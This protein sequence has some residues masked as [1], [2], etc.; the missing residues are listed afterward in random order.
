MDCPL[1]LRLAM[2]HVLVKVMSAQMT[3]AQVGRVLLCCT[4]EKH[5]PVSQ[6]SWKTN[7]H[8]FLLMKCTLP[9]KRGSCLSLEAECAQYL[10]FW[11][12]SQKIQVYVI[13]YLKQ[14]M[15]PWLWFVSR[16]L[17]KLYSI[18]PQEHAQTISSISNCGDSI[19][20]AGTC[21]VWYQYIP[22][23]KWHSLSPAVTTQFFLIDLCGM[24]LDVIAT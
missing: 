19:I 14:C 3:K 6:E 18:H 1:T 16:D 8:P 9:Y 5:T 24:I 2:W 21:I 11:L 4:N 13:G 22:L 20:V 17:K 7:F 23:C 15:Y 12:L 10:L